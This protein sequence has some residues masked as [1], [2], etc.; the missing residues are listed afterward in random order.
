MLITPKIRS[1]RFLLTLATVLAVTGVCLNRW[2]MVLQ[3]MAVPVMSFDTWVM[4]YPSWQEVATTILPVAYGIMLI[5]ISYRYLPV[6]PN[7]AELNPLEPESP[8]VTATETEDAAEEGA[9]PELAAAE[10]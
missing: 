7:E 6:F 9:A 3:V 5:M 10:A 4:Y 1:N 8:A 2:V